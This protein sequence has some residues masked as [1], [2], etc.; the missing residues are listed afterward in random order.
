MNNRGRFQAQGDNLEES[1]AWAQDEPLYS[2]EARVKLMN[3]K[4]KLSPREKSQNKSVY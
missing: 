1:E 2:V 4:E 3:L